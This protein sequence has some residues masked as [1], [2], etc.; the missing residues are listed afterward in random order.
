M[1]WSVEISDSDIVADKRFLSDLLEKLNVT[2]YV[3][4]N[5]TYLTSEQFELLSTGSEVWELAN[6]ICSVVSE[7]SNSPLDTGVRFKLANLYEQ[8][9]NGSRSRYVFPPITA[10]GTQSSLLTTQ[11]GVAVIGRISEEE[12]ARLEAERVEREYQEKLA[13][14]SHRVISAFHNENALRVHRFLRQEL[15][16]IRMYHI[17]ELMRNDL[18][19]NLNDLASEK[20]WF[21]LTRS[22]N[23]PEVFGDESRHIVSNEEPPAQP[24]RLEEAQA[25]ISGVANLWFQQIANKLG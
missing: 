17:Y 4:D 10:T 24:M 19:K 21:R 22:V 11:I 1:R 20:N 3:E 2:L 16:P 13:L 6:R 5:K 12:K 14:V 8:K 23:H 9:D 25:F 18:G 15:T 7:A